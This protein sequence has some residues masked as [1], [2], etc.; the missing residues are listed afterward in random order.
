MRRRYYDECNTLADCITKA[1]RNR[2]DDENLWSVSFAASVPMWMHERMSE[3]FP[4]VPHTFGYGGFI[5]HAA[6]QM[7]KRTKCER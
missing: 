4:L 6:D 7:R 5:H 3:P 1:C 2:S